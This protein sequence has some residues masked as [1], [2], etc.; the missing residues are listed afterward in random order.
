VRQ[1][2]PRVLVLEVELKISSSYGAFNISY[3]MIF[4]PGSGII[5]AFTDKAT[6]EVSPEFNQAVAM[7]I[8][9][10][11]ILTVIFTIGACRSSWILFLD[12][13]FLDLDLLLLACGYMTGNNSL[14]LAG[15]SFGFVV[16]FLSCEPPTTSSTN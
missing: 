2:H 6:G 4:I 16:A 8:W 12:L 13:F 15:N 3:A 14:L 7:Y 11:F 1:P 9:A 10:W 5:S